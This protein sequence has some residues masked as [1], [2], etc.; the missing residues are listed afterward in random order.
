[1]LVQ[2]HNRCESQPFYAREHACAH[3]IVTHIDVVRS[4]GVHPPGT[5]VHVSVRPAAECQRGFHRIVVL[6]DISTCDERCHNNVLFCEICSLSTGFKPKK[7]H[8]HSQTIAHAILSRSLSNKTLKQLNSPP[9]EGREQSATSAAPGHS[10][11][12][13]REHRKGIQ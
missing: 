2:H 13:R 11:W 12:I 8:S 1:M 10:L 3:A 7:I 6:V 4:A 9:F 5:G